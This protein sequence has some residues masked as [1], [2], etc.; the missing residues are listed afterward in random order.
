MDSAHLWVVMTLVRSG[1]GT[2]KVKVRS[3]VHIPN[4]DTLSL[5]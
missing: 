5:G 3:V 1:I 2:A 4:K